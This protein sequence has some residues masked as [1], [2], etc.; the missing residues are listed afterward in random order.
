[1][2]NGN[3][4]ELKRKEQKKKFTTKRNKSR[5]ANR[6]CESLRIPAI[7][8]FDSKVRWDVDERIPTQKPDL[9]IFGYNRILTKKHHSSLIHVIL[10]LP[11]V[12]RYAVLAKIVLLLGYMSLSLKSG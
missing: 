11:T 4:F 2:S 5:P 3:I 6:T 8:R 10:L 7:L 9:Q 12:N 1:V